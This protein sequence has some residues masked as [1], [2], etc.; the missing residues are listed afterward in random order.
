[1]DDIN[2]LK[3]DVFSSSYNKAS[4]ALRKLSKLK[5]DN[6][7]DFL[8]SLL[9]NNDP[10][11]RNRAALALGDI[12]DNRAV[13]SLLKAILN[14]NNNYYNGTLV[15][16]LSDLDCSKKLIDLFEILFY[17]EYEP[18]M[19]VIEIL[20][21]QEFEFTIKDLMDIQKKWIYLKDNPDECPDFENVKDDI[22]SIVNEF[23]TYLKEK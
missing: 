19:G 6:V 3:K 7:V 10:G 20:K 16:V 5:E 9:D 23:M 12:G 13:D 2:S 8:I 22:E 18:R 17:H 1:M 4:I 15:H 21:E 14:K 11:L